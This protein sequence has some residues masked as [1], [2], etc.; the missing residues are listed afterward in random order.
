[1]VVVRA[2]LAAAALKA[3]E[4]MVLVVSH[5]R[6]FLNEVCN[7]ITVIAHQHLA[8]FRGTFKDSWGAAEM[9]ELLAVKAK[10]R[11]CV[12]R[13]VKDWEPCSTFRGGDVIALGGAETQ[14]FLRLLRWMEANGRLGRLEA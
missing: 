6:S 8:V 5:N 11:Y 14:A 2:F 12:L 3:Y 7:E 4:G 1:M 13:V 9:A 10:P